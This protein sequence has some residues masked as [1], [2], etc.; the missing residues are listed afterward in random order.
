MDT[1]ALINL[2]FWVALVGVGVIVGWL[3]GWKGLVGYWAVGIA[4][5]LI[6]ALGIYVN[7]DTGEGSGSAAGPA[8]IMMAVGVPAMWSAISLPS[9]IVGMVIRH[10]T[11]DKGAET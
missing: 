4:V 11:K 9:A 5:A 6:M 1:D 8:M 3:Y 2:G 7:S 10:F